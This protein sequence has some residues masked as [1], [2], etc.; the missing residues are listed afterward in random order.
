MQILIELKAEQIVKS[1]R[2][3]AGGYLLARSPEEITLGDIIRCMHGQVFETPA[4]EDENCPAELRRAWARL[5]TILEEAANSIQFQQ[6]L[7]EGESSQRMY[8]I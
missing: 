3:K 7:E 1:V 4:L 6:L 5:G 8:Y 2:G